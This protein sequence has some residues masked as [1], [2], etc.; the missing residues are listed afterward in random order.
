M[1]GTVNSAFSTLQFIVRTA[2]S[3]A[4]LAYATDREINASGSLLGA[5]STDQAV[6]VKVQF[7]RPIPKRIVDERGTWI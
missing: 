1:N 2:T 6:R 3:T 5:S 4:A 7:N